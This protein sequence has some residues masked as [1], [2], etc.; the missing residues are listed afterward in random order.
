MNLQLKHISSL[1][2]LVLL[3]YN[4]NSKFF[5][6]AKMSLSEVEGDKCFKAF[7]LKRNQL[8]DIRIKIP[9]K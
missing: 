7:P 1:T 2:L 9:N 3:L 5:A 4:V 6:A 8:L